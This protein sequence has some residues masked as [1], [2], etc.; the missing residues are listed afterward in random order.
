M[1]QR[2]GREIKMRFLLKKLLASTLG[3]TLAASL[4]AVLP[5]I[6]SAESSLATTLETLK[7][8]RN[9]VASIYDSKG[10]A[11][12][13]CYKSSG[14]CGGTKTATNQLSLPAGGYVKLRANPDPQH[15]FSYDICDAADSCQGQYTA[16]IYAYKPG[17]YLLLRVYPINAP[18]NWLLVFSLGSAD[19]YLANNGSTIL[20]NF[21]SAILG[22]GI[23]N[24]APTIVSASVTGTFRVGETLTGVESYSGVDVEISRQWKRSDT[25][26]GLNNIG[27][28]DI[29]NATNNTYTL[30]NADL[31]KYIRYNITTRNMQ[32]YGTGLTSGRGSDYVLVQAALSAA[33]TPELGTYTR[34][35][36]GFTVAISNYSTAYTWAGTATNSGSVS[37]SGT[38]G[39]GLATIT[40]VSAN[41]ASVA[42]IT[43][44]RNDYRNG[45]AV[46]ASTTSLN[47]ALT[48]TFGTYTRT[49]DGFTVGISNYDTAYTWDGTATNGG[50]ITF[51][52][53]AN[54]GLA[55]ITGVA[56]N[57]A[58]VATITTTRSTYATGSAN[59]SSTTSLA[60]AL[61]P[62]YGTYTQTSTGY[63]VQISNYS[64][65][66]TWSGTA[67]NGATVAI[68]NTGLVTISNLSAGYATCFSASSGLSSYAT[69]V[70]SRSGYPS[71][72]SRT[73]STSALRAALTPTLGVYT[74][75]ADGFTVTITNYN[76]LFT[77]SGS[78]TRS[79]SVSFSGTCND[80]GLATITGVTANTASVA[81]ITTTL[82]GYTS[83]N[84]VSASTNSLP[85][86]LPPTFSS[87]TPAFGGFTFNVTNYNGEYTFS[88]SSTSGSATAGTRVGN[89]LPITVSG[90]SSGQSAT[91]SIS[92]TR[93]GYADGHGS[94]GG[95]AKTSALT[96]T[97]GTPGKW[98]SSA[99]SD[100]GQ[101][102]VFAG[103]NSN[104]FVSPNNGVDWDAVSSTKA[105]TSVAT[106]ST[107]Q[108]MLAGAM[109]SNLYLST[110]YGATWSSKAVSKNWRAV[111]MSADG[112]TLYGAVV[113]GF[114][115]K[116]VNGG[117][118]WSQVGSQQNWRALATS[119]NG[120]VVIAAPYGGTLYVS[121]DSGSTWT[122]RESAR[123]WSSVSIADN[124]TVMVA[125]VVGGGVYLSSDSGVTWS[126][127]AGVESKTWNSVS[128][129]S[130]CSQFAISS[131][132]GNL[133]LLSSQGVKIADASN[134]LSKWSTVTLNSAG[135]QIIAGAQSGALR[136]SVDSG[137]TWS[138][139]TR[140]AS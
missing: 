28:T 112:N 126:A 118:S 135:T 137:S 50:L 134:N 2:E 80:G 102:V 56:A 67:V 53:T 127:I 30:T 140:I 105:W 85:A 21:D 97:S 133:Y 66:F 124:G 93:S 41:T 24:D 107:G 31:G 62:M 95:T 109:N 9:K 65:E 68:S 136:R 7:F 42:T 33:L 119:Q 91:V 125:T 90:L 78:A 48:P 92:T 29:S 38:N 120:Q 83:G 18:R 5:V 44:T 82:S 3:F 57:T 130:T 129:N 49:A 22:Q 20:W 87:V 101:Y 54:N 139:R 60:A 12:M 26:R 39:N 121:T 76:P 75:T 58:S 96:P 72:S 52:G 14:T 99:I 55:T 34:T 43:T 88:L 10:Q 23:Y 117:S 32:G 1:S 74:R 71:G 132:A 59:T 116:S 81:T 106:S 25:Y 15:L 70:T 61:N 63:T 11:P 40:G 17:E 79:G 51:S 73:T 131:V 19:P 35:A 111:A 100:N 113:S 89:S 86:Q 64:N 94:R 110:N 122:S 108:K 13:D 77:W 123:N 36:N 98:N 69:I 84:V 45:S 128:C 16:N 47:R 6:L 103:T 46:T 27:G 4:L 37:F 115:F 114:I 8:S 104:L 138:L